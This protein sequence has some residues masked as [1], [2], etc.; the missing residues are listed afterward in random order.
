MSS[1]LR[2]MRRMIEAGRM[3]IAMQAAF[4]LELWSI[5]KKIARALSKPRARVA[6]PSCNSSGKTAF[7]GA[8]ALTFYAAFPDA[9][10]IT[11][12]AREDQ[13]RDNLWGEIRRWHSQRTIDFPGFV[14]ASGMSIR[15]GSR[16]LTGISPARPEGIKGYH[17]PHVLVVVDEASYLEDSMAGAIA[18]LLASGDARL[19]LIFNPSDSNTFAAEAC[20]S[21]AYDVIPIPGW[22]TPGLS[23]ISNEEV[24]ARWG[25]ELDH[26]RKPRTEPV[27]KGA[28]LITPEYL[29]E[30]LASG[31]GPGT[32]DWET[33]VEAKFW[34]QGLDV[35]VSRAMY[36]AARKTAPAPNDQIVFGVDLASYGDSESVVAVRKGNELIDIYARDGWRID[37]FWHEIVAPMVARYNPRYVI[38]DA[39]G[40]GAGSFS[41]AYAVC[42]PRALPF[43]GSHPCP[44]D[45]LNLRSMHYWNL[46][47]R[48]EWADIAI[49]LDD[50]VL[51]RQL[52]AI[53]YQRRN[54][55][56]VV[57][58]KQEL[59]KR[60]VR[61][62]DRAD[63]LMYCYS[64]DAPEERVANPIDETD[65]AH[66][67]AGEQL[68]WDRWNRKLEARFAGPRRPVPL[69]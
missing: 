43:R 37:I 41:D 69:R 42:G 64:S 59:R 45:F 5:Q 15:D 44:T 68:M 60:G 6:V 49:G 56:V 52:T 38:W 32:Y 34:A 30:L 25:V 4:D 11:T 2:V 67:D 26:L 39:D 21:G 24:K 7:A 35:L 10:V 9:K 51:R 20:E 17:S 62:V 31:K 65:L 16:L 33:S 13:L 27:P 55:K 61:S 8:A 28:E 14:P 53:T 36:D 54:G 23:K 46:H 12:A 18:T 57:E 3:D 47:R 19:L 1:H 58:A 22:D 66:R 40:P 50:S 48:F 63:A 29:D